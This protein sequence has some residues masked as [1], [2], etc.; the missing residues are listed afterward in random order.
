MYHG[1]CAGTRV[2]VRSRH[3]TSCGALARHS[4]GR[5]LAAPRQRSVAPR[6][7]QMSSSAEP[8]D[9][10][11]SSEE[12]EPS[13]AAHRPAPTAVK[14]EGTAAGKRKAAPAACDDDDD[15]DDVM[16]MPAPAPP[17]MSSAAGSKA[18]A[19]EDDDV[20]F[21]GRTGQVALQDFPQYG[22]KA[23]TLPY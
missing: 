22:G 10:C 19:D 13:A 15:D 14:A 5:L 4:R 20:Q 6:H 18:A 9:L 8:I 12:D 3:R 23:R 7:P 16:W 21:V 11:T 2:G 17:D 1:M